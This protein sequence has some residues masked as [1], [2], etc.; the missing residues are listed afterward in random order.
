[1]KKSFILLALTICIASTSFA[2]IWR[3]NNTGV[4][5]DFTTAQAAND[6][7]SVVNGDTLHF[8]PSG[9]SYGEFSLTKR[10]V[11][12]GNGYFLGS[13]IGGANP[14][15][16]ANTAA[17]V[18]SNM[19]LG[20]GAANSVIMGMTISST[21]YIGYGTS[22]N[23]ILFRRNRVQGTVYFYNSGSTNVQVLQCYIDGGIAQGGTHTNIM[24]ANN[25]ILAGTSFDGDDNGTFQNNI[26]HASGAAY[27][28][29]FQ[30]F[31][32]RSNIM[33]AGS[34]STLT[35]CLVESNISYSNYFGTANN[36]QANID[37]ST[38]F[39]GYPTQGT[40]SND[41]RFVLK[42]PGPG[43]TTGYGSV[44]CG[45]YGNTTPYVKSGMP[46]VPSVYKLSVP[47]I[48]TNNVLSVIIS[49]KINQ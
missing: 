5:A 23:N 47:P 38:V 25:I 20:S 35:N 40:N 24:I 34:I 9:T 1:M 36:N 12:I 49:T 30:N 2:K 48:V 27:G 18:V 11:V 46:D 29:A 39:V 21:I 3:I 43:I 42:N 45:A 28:S 33:V 13:G 10:L 32:L 17:S 8:E 41:G 31:T 37:M 15:L 26:M 19:Y 7:A 6:N 14:D 22:T 44:D 16:Q 4:P